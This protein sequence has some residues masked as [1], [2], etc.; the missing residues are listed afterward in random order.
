MAELGNWLAEWFPNG[1]RKRDGKNATLTLL[2]VSA[3]ERLCMYRM[4]VCVFTVHLDGIH[5]VCVCVCAL[6]HAHVLAQSL[7]CSVIIIH[8][9]FFFLTNWKQGALWNLSIC[10]IYILNVAYLYNLLNINLFC[11]PVHAFFILQYVLSLWML[12]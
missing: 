6:F 4:V 2:S 7:V 3:V 1:E 9:R 10:N 12:I 8:A 11:L 5:G